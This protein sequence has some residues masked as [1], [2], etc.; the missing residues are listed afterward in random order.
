MKCES[1]A[2]KESVYKQSRHPLLSFIFTLYLR[3]SSVLSFSLFFLLISGN[4]HSKNIMIQYLLVEHAY[5][6]SAER[7]GT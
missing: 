6:I 3:P 5:I 4:K 2:L 7:T 1:R